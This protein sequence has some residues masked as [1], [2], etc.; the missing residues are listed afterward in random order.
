MPYFHHRR[1]KMLI[2]S[3]ATNEGFYLRF[4]DTQVRI[5][6]VGNS[7]KY[8]RIG[9]AAPPEVDVWREELQPKP[10]EPDE[11]KAR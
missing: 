11:L 10:K 5:L 2:L 1:S 6:V 3:R 7:G 8:V 4:G 9:I